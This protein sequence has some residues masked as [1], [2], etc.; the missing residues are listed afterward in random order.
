[1]NF[2][3]CFCFFRILHGRALRRTPKFENQLHSFSQSLVTDA[4]RSILVVVQ[5]P[6]FLLLLLLL[7]FVAAATLLFTLCATQ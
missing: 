2:A 6:F 1:M 4:I 7:L 3:S 5:F